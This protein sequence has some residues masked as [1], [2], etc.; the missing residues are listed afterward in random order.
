MNKTYA[1]SDL[2][3]RYDLYQKI[4]N[5]T[6]ANDTIIYLGDAC[7]RGPDG[8]RLVKALLNNN[9]WI[10]LKGNHED[11]MVKG[12]REYFR[13]E[14]GFWDSYDM[15]LWFCNGGES[16]FNE[17][18]EDDISREQLEEYLKVIDELPLMINAQTED[19]KE[20][21]LCHAGYS[22]DRCFL[23]EDF[24]KQCLWGRNH[25]NDDYEGDIIIVHG[26]TPVKHISSLLQTT[27]GYCGMRK[28]D[29]DMG[30]YRS[31]MTMM[32]ELETLEEI[33]VQGDR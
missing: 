30:A 24:K 15:Y 2:H 7:D 22:P 14:E 4:D 33:L 1:V 26:H 5:M 28:Y 17:I 10:Y 8:W 29:I 27:A 6:D 16:T 31:G 23:Y 12:M 21:I 9:K 19:G 25:F 20:I 3:G 18:I 13:Q 11:M 32:L